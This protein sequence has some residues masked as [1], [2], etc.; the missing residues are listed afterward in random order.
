MIK[1]AFTLIVLLF[2]AII[3]SS[4]TGPLTKEKAESLLRKAYTGNNDRNTDGGS[5]TELSSL[6]IDSIHQQG[7]TARVFY[8]ISGRVD[9]GSKYPKELPAG[10]QEDQFKKGITGWKEK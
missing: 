8:R 6:E 10:E 7:D 5:H 4:C 1:I 3:F 2:T 9:N